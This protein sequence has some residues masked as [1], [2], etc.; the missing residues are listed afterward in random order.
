MIGARGIGFSYGERPLL[1]DV[2][3]S[4][5]AGQVLGVLGINGSG[6]TTL[7]RLLLGFLR[8]RMGE[9]LLEGRAVHEYDRREFASRVAAVPQETAV[10]FPFTVSE[11]VLLGRAPHLGALGL[12]SRS[13]LAAAE[14]AMSDCGILP[15]ASRPIHE[16]SG[17]ELRR[18][19]IA[20]A[21]AQQTPVLLLDE[22]TANLDLHHQVAIFSVLRREASRGRTVLVVVHDVNAALAHCDRVILL[23][24]G[25]IAAAGAPAEVLTESRVERVYGVPVRALTDPSSTAR[26]LFPAR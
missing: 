16:L 10:D 13:D 18:A 3:F 17:G 5:E 21:L 23:H 8:P 4:A 2:S 6:K 22:P 20:R 26:F 19:S 7:L 1:R 9:A 14:A 25:T 15:L 11:L 24:E 12:E